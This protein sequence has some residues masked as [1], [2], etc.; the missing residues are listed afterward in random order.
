MTVCS[1]AG[2]G[3]CNEISTYIVY[4]YLID[5]LLKTIGVIPSLYAL[6]SKRTTPVYNP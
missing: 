4:T 5:T 3:K 1:V 2:I 6:F